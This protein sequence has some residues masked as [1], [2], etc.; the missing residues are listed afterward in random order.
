MCNV[1]TG[2]LRALQLDKSVLGG[3]GVIFLLLS[4]QIDSSDSVK[5]IMRTDLVI[6]LVIYP[7]IS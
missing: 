4:F 3:N 7:V 1:F 2:V 5:K 6:Y